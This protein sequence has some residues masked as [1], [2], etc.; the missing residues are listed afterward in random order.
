MPKQLLIAILVAVVFLVVGV[1]IYTR[2]Q[3]PT[4]RSAPAPSLTI[5]ITSLRGKVESVGKD[6]LL[7]AVNGKT[8]QVSLG[9][10][11][12]VSRLGVPASLS[13]LA[14]GQELLVVAQTSNLSA[15]TYNALTILIEK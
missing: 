5:P 1:L 6:S 3:V 12:E 9:S 7:L 14:A 4:Q 8:K 10:V 11:R 13:D 2:Y 15:N